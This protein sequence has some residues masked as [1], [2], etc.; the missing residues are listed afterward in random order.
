MPKIVQPIQGLTSAALLSDGAGRIADRFAL[1]DWPE[2][3]AVLHTAGPDEIIRRVREAESSDP[4]GA[5][6]PRGKTHDDA[7]L[8]H[9]TQFGGRFV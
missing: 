4:E 7:M 2:V 1:A 5:K 8:A 6:W 9:C 3:L